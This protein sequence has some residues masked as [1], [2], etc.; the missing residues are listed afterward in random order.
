MANTAQARKRARQ[1]EATRKRNAAQKSEIRTA[2][3]KVKNDRLPGPLPGRK[4]WFEWFMKGRRS[5][6]KDADVVE[7][8]EASRVAFH[9]RYP[10]CFLCSIADESLLF[11][12]Q[13]EQ[14]VPASAEGGILGR[15]CEALP[16]ESRIERKDLER[17]AG[18]LQGLAEPYPYLYAIA[19]GT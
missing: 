10:L 18:F 11:P 3:K 14:L 4:T 9:F 5:V 1:A 8:E 17:I 6:N 16:E 12:D 2:M 13:T 7:R 15:C 19:Y